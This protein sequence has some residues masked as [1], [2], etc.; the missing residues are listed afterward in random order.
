L[1][2]NTFDEIKIDDDSVSVRNIDSSV[3]P[4]K[5]QFL[6]PLSP[7][8]PIIEKSAEAN[9]ASSEKEFAEKI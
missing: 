4:P 2:N 9:F 7:I 1:G 8:S 5:N 6:S 3:E